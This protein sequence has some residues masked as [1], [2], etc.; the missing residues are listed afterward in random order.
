M[1]QWQ[2][3]NIKEYFKWIYYMVS[4]YKKTKL[5][6]R[7]VISENKKATMWLVFT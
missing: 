7:L 5:H 3:E 4:F 1:Q 2:K 6:L